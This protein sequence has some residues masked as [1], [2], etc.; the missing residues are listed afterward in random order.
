MGYSQFEVTMSYFT[1]TFYSSNIKE[2]E[3]KNLLVLVRYLLTI[4]WAF[5]ASTIV[6]TQIFIISFVFK[7]FKAQGNNCLS[8]VLFEWEWIKRCI[9]EGFSLR[10][11]WYISFYVILNV[12][13]H[14]KTLID[15]ERMSDQMFF[16]VTDFPNELNSLEHY[17]RSSKKTLLERF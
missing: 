1:S 14:V 15:S 17:P 5:S 9:L 2:I 12:V 10:G 11:V 7:S 13:I 8:F 6:F 16:K 3:Y 4:F